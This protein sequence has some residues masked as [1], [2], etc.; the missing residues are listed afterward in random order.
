MLSRGAGQRTYGVT[1]ENCTPSPPNDHT[2]E[3]PANLRQYVKVGHGGAEVF[4]TNEFVTA[5]VEGRRP[6]ADVYQGVAYCAPG[7]CI[8]ESANKNGEWIKVPDFGWHS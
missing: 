1:F 6:Q 5:L 7:I 8:D 2:D 4:I 3:L